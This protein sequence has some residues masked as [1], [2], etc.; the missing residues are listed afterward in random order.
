MNEKIGDRIAFWGF[1]MTC[2]IVLYH[3]GPGKCP[4]KGGPVEQYWC[5]A[6]NRFMNDVGILAMSFFFAVTGFLLCH[7][8]GRSEYFHKVRRRVMTLLVPYLIW[9]GLVALYFFARGSCEPME[10]LERVFL[11]RRWPPD[12]ALWYVYVVFLLALLSPLF[13]VAFKGKRSGLVSVVLLSVTCYWSSCICKPSENFVNQYGILLNTLTYLPAYFLGC[14]YGLR[15]SKE[16]DARGLSHCAVFLLIAIVINGWCGGFVIK[17]LFSV[18]PILLLYTA[19]APNKVRSWPLLKLSFLIYALHQPLF[20]EI[21]TSVRRGIFAVYPSP[22]VFN[23][24]GRLFGLG[25]VILAAALL[26]FVLR[27]FCPSILTVLTGGRG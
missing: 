5:H 21:L 9:E 16:D 11:F 27:R 18:L 22:F 24:V 13:V 8:F 15:F 19:P 7:G 14:F 6:I 1:L 4:I 2:C 26:S 20:V 10:L 12:G 25:I 23:S 3:C 17:C